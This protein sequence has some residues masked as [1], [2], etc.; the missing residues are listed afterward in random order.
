MLVRIDRECIHEN[1]DMYSIANR[2]VPTY[3]CNHCCDL[4][5]IWWDLSL[6]ARYVGRTPELLVIDRH[7]VPV[8]WECIREIS[9]FNGM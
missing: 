2:K 5:P 3:T 6:V 9:L 4:L 1:R 7:V 8:C